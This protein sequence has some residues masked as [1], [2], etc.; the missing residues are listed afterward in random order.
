M[1]KTKRF[2][3]RKRIGARSTLHRSQFRREAIR[4][5]SSS[6]A[7]PRRRNL[8][9]LRGQVGTIGKAWIFRGRYFGWMVLSAVIAMAGGINLLIESGGQLIRQQLRTA[10]G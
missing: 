3:M 6:I 10:L 7:P 9:R 1:L 8:I 2:T 4:S 5:I